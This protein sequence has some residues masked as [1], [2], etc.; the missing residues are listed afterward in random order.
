MQNP[1]QS[2]EN[3]EVR[4]DNPSFRV[5]D[6]V[7]VHFRIKEGDKER[8][9]VFEGVCIAYRRGGNRSAITVRKISF[10]QGVERIF[11]LSSPRIERIEVVAQG[12]VRRAKLYYLRALRGKKA[13]IRQRVTW[14]KNASVGGS[15][16]ASSPGAV[17]HVV[18]AAAVEGDQGA[19]KSAGGGPS[20]S[21]A[22]T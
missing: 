8:V 14:G 11:P 18:A 3:K 5:G 1:L 9:Q 12:H 22:A 16:R 15:A 10:A 21:S 13:R 17:D 19:P 2:I 4:S 6:T 7:R 20:G